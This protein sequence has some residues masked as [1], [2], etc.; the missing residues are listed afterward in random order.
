MA[1]T[2]TYREIDNT[3]E[4][5]VTYEMHYGVDEY[6]EVFAETDRAALDAG[7]VLR[8]VTRNTTVYV[9]NASLLADAAIRACMRTEG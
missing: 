6:L 9:V 4:T 7:R 2:I 8:S 3:H 1:I 5:S